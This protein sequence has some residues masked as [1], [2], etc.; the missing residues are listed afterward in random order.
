MAEALVIGILV[1]DILGTPI[2]T[3]PEKGKL[4][5]LED[6]Q[7][8]IGGCAAN[9]GIALAR[10]GI[11]TEGIGIVG[12]DSLGD[13][14]VNTLKAE[15]VGVQNIKRSSEK[16]TSGTIVMV[17]ED[18]ER[19]FFHHIGANGELRAE[20]V[21]P[22]AIEEARLVH[23]GGT[24]LLPRFDGEGTKKVLKRAKELGKL[25]SL[26]TAWDT[27]GRWLE[28]VEDSLSYVDIFIPSIEEAREISGRKD[29]REIADFFLARG[30]KT[31]A[32]KM[33]KE[34]CYIRRG[35]EEIRLPSLKVEVRD[36][37]G[38]GDAFAGGFLAGVLKGYNLKG[39]AQFASTI[40]ASCIMAIGA[41]P[42]LPRYEEAIEL[43][44]TFYPDFN[45]TV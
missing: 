26:D 13:F 36:T 40:A 11:R 31:V 4:E 12:D 14:I 44:K 18:G 23:I 25:T 37:T 8:H 30:V 16:S 39:C 43:A 17:S 38:A 9:T 35:D 24:F 3:L 33:G 1:A 45:P 15:G 6:L 42:G 5:L 21:N 41:T 29:P 10:L 32:L 19:S 20:D 34:G 2:V 7:L 27:T 28:V 22:E